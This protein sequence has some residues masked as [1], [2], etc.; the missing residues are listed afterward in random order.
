MWI[1]QHGLTLLLVGLL[2]GVGSSH[3]SADDSSSE[4]HVPLRVEKLQDLNSDNARLDLLIENIKKKQTLRGLKSRLESGA[5]DEV[6][7][8]DAQPRVS[9][10]EPRIDDTPS[11]SDHAKSRHASDLPL[12]SKIYGSNGTLYADLIYRNGRALPRARAGTVL[13]SG[14]TVESVAIGQVMV[15]TETGEKSLSFVPRMAR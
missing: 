12:V 1:K 11:Q 2:S 9:A 7:N 13:P 5:V 8:D 14:E 10:P 3:A 15:D 6:D 4:A